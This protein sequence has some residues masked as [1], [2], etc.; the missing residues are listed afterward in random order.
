MKPDT[1]PPP[2]AGKPT[3]HVLLLLIALCILCG[4]LAIIFN[5]KQHELQQQLDTIQRRQAGKTATSWQPDGDASA[6]E[7]EKVFKL[8]NLLSQKDAAI[9]ELQQK[10]IALREGRIMETRLSPSALP[11][12][13]RINRQKKPLERVVETPV[14]DIV[15]A[16][17]PIPTPVYRN[18]ANQESF[19]QNLDITSMSESQSTTHRELLKHLESLRLCVAEL[20]KNR[21]EDPTGE[22]RRTLWTEEQAISGLML[23]ER[24]ALFSN[25]AQELG[26]DDESSLLFAEFI[27]R[28]D[29][30]TTF[31]SSSQLT[32]MPQPMSG[33]MPPMAEPDNGSMPPPPMPEQ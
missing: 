24:Q 25:M 9:S 31:E 21:G 28:I 19:L 3:N 14:T 8:V 32:P 4:A 33:D 17:Q 26:Y 27:E 23:Q 16:I 6:G 18:I 5:Q 11:K 13:V 2:G 7:S 15:A 20:D 30:M 29:S 22:L 10:M 12:S 1:V